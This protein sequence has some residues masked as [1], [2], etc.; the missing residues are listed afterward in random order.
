MTAFAQEILLEG[1]DI[2]SLSPRW[3]DRYLKRNPRVKTKNSTLLES[4]RVRGSTR[5]AYED[6]YGRLKYQIDSVTG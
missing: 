6:F 4:A 3:I 5:E 2:E 1:G